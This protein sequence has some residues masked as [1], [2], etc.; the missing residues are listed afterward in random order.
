MRTKLRLAL[1]LLVASHAPLLA[2][3]ITRI[4]PDGKPHK[5]EAREHQFF[6]DGEPTLLIAGEMHLSRI[7][8]EF[9]EQRMK[10]A[11]AMGINTVSLYLFWNE[12]Q[13]REGVFDFEGANDVRRFVKLAQDNGLW[14]VI[15]PGPYCCAETEF[16][17]VPWWLLK[18]KD[19][20]IRSN[21][22]KFLDYAR[23]YIQKVGEQTADL[24]VTRG[25][26]IVMV[27]LD[28]EYGRID[29]YMRSL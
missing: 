29:D 23:Q 2:Q 11:R 13:P 9:W 16:G 25:G 20:K 17:G 22:A 3:P 18:H 21:D 14:V 8:P 1:I 15:R 12:V 10:Q 7:R 26:P 27:Q 19:I 4:A 28:N 6:I 24:Q 5:F